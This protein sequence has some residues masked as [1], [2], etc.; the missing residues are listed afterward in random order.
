MRNFAKILSLTAF[1]AFSAFGAD[2][3]G[4][5]GHW[6]GNVELPN[7]QLGVEVDLDM[8]AKDWVGSIS[9]PAQGASGIPLDNIA[10]ADGKLSFRIQGAPGDPTL[11]GKLSDEGKTI[12]GEFAAGGG[13]FPFKLTRTGDAKVEAAKPNARV[14]DAFVG[15]WDAALQLPGATLQLN[16]KLSNTAQGAE[17]LLTSVDQ[18]NAPMPVNTVEQTDTKLVLKIKMIGGEFRGDIDKEGAEIR[19]TW[20]QMGNSL[21]LIFKKTR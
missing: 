8:P 18:G 17:A 7:R 3:A 4:P 11:S 5:R 9:I 2:D 12:A 19:G 6:S 14:G 10:F 20:S 21:P 16:L 1:L 15:S 13:A